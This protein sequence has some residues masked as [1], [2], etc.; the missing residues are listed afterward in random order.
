[1]NPVARACAVMVALA[2]IVHGAVAAPES[3]LAVPAVGSTT[4]RVLAPSV[5]EI[6]HVG[7]APAEWKFADDA[8]SLQ[9]PAPAEL[10][11]QVAGRPVRVA[12]LGFKRQ[13][14][15]APLSP[16]DLRIG[17]F[18][19]A[20]LES[21]V[22]G[23]AAVQVEDLSGRLALTAPLTADAAASRASPVLHVNQVGYHP[24][25]PKRAY[26]GYYLGSLGEL[27]LAEGTPFSLVDAAGAAVFTGAL[28]ASPDS[29]WASAVHP[30]YQHVLCADFS[31]F[32]RPGTY[33]V[34]VPGLGASYPFA[35]DAGVPAA[36]ARAYALGLYHQRCGTALE[37]PYTRF[38][39]G[40]CHRA[41]ASVPTMASAHTNRV[42]AA[43]TGD[44]ARHQTNPLRLAD[45]GSSLYPFVETGER[46]VH[47]G[48][49]DAGDY[50]KYTINSAHLIH[51]LVLAVDALPGVSALDNLG[52][53]ESGDG[54]P[55]LLQIA[56]HEAEFLCRMQD[57]DGGFY[58][59]VYPR[60]RKYEGDVP[61]DRGDPQVVF[62]KTT[63]ATA[64]AT[65]ALAQIGSSPA[66][67]KANPASAD[68]CLDRARAGWRFLEAAIEHHGRAGSFQ[69][70][71]H[72][73]QTFGAD[74][75]LCWAAAEV[76]LA[77]GDPAAQ[78]AL[79]AFD[80]A[81]RRWGWIPVPECYG[82]AARSY[83]LAPATG[84]TRALD[85][86]L[87][88][89]CRAALA[90]AG[91]DRL[92]DARANAYGLSFPR[93]TK[94]YMNPGWFFATDAAFDMTI[95]GLIEPDPRY[96]DALVACVDFE[97]GA[98][99]NSVSFL[100]GLGWKRPREIVSQ[101]AR[102]DRRVLPPSGIPLGCLRT[103]PSPVGGYGREL[104][105]LMF[106]PPSGPD[107]F[108]LYDRWSDDFNV[109]TEW[110][111]ATAARG[112][113]SLAAWMAATDLRRQPYRSVA[114]RIDGAP[115]TGFR[116]G[117]P[118]RLTAAGEGLD[119]GLPRLVWEA[120]AHEPAFDDGTG[121][122]FTP[123]A[124]GPAWVELEVQWVDGRRGFAALELDV[125]P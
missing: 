78:R 18:L 116:V 104:K 84:R 108:A 38:V 79:Q 43:A 80:P 17:N 85:P 105:S 103:A 16:R 10:A 101:M 70:I 117:V 57:A 3:P 47:G 98:N 13:V 102:N 100:T 59:L 66:F 86:A 58:F 74:D 32:T 111:S 46:D 64:A 75:E 12:A 53:P 81:I 82:H 62:P 25:G 114:V 115:A 112:L 27:A 88:A 28:T 71:T 2:A 33:R 56:A 96:R 55:D 97:A 48:H 92:E 45:V 30:Q 51:Y 54:V 9:L 49:H 113:A 35:I 107:A 76:Y 37:L 61:P 11:V 69:K 99:P 123:H 8:G 122:T 119:R 34:V 91:R 94:R 121:F 50:S 4:L 68:A 26:A 31:R 5:L 125:A 44:F 110:V 95:A 40:A 73:G 7:A 106:P 15:Y 20:R 36:F 22:V 83:A 41:P 6:E 1:M 124:P 14:R 63:A 52:L 65:A 120:A 93:T 77:T 19:Y 21:P 72:Y 109:A 89:R 42:L 90:R 24:S 60:D 23:D 118:A 87:L 67:R 39:H 29:G